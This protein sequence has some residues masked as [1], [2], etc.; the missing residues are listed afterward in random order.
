MDND[1]SEDHAVRLAERAK[2]SASVLVGDAKTQVEEL[3]SHAT[4]AA[5]RAYGAARDQ[6]R[7]AA[8]VVGRSVD[9]QPLI[10]LLIAGL[11]CGAVGYVLARR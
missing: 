9:R 7:E 4:E 11:V 8:T 2:T 6:V 1:F 5:K 3:A 10:A